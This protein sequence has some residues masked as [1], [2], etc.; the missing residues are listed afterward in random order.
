MKERVEGDDVKIMIDE[1]TFE[2]ASE[3][4]RTLCFAKK[5]LSQKEYDEFEDQFN[6]NLMNGKKEENEKLI[7]DLENGLEFLAITAVKD[8]L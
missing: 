7:V 2:L 3:G 8:L 1:K 5:T 6:D 4:L